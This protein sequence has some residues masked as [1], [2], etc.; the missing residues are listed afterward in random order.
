MIVPALPS[1]SIS[2]VTLSPILIAAHWARL[3][4]IHKIAFDASPLVFATLISNVPDSL[5]HVSHL[6]GSCDDRK[7]LVDQID[8]IFGAKIVAKDADYYVGQ[9]QLLR[10]MVLEHKCAEEPR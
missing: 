5:G 4:Y 6:V 8:S 1:Q 2:K 3:E 7:R 10:A 9:A